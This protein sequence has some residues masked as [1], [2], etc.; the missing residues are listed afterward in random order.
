MLA[1]QWVIRLR[2]KTDPSL[3]GDA[4]P[5]APP[6]QTLGAPDFVSL[7][8]ILLAGCVWLTIRRPALL[9]GLM[10]VAAATDVLDGWLARRLHR[11]GG[12]GVWLDPLCDKIF[13]VSALAAVW[14][15]R[16]PPLW[17]L[18]VIGAREVLQIITW[19]VAHGRV[20]FDFRAA[21]IGK[22]ATVLQFAA[23]AA[24]L[25]DLPA[26]QALAFG[27]GL[28]GAAAGGYYVFRSL[29]GRSCG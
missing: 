25:L 20:R 4:G 15:A 17:L 29:G 2:S 8:R 21:R 10:I 23:V 9:L 22:A 5:V 16:R 14:V 1:L 24:I 7:S 3:R 6:P 19:A 11:S 27:A 12:R 26:A 13:I 28:A 18:A